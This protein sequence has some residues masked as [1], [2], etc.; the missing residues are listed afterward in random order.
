MATVERLAQSATGDDGVWRFPDGEEYYQR[1][2][3]WFTTTDLT[4]DEVHQL[5]LA[6]VDRI[7][8]EMRSIMG[9]VGFSGTLKNFLCLFGKIRSCVTPT[10]MKVGSSTLRMRDQLLR[11]WRKSYPSISVCFQKLN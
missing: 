5:G 6:N 3:K 11:A 8:D 10:P 4:A 7:H 2:L 9:Q 1:L